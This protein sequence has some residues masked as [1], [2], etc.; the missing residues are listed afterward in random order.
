MAVAITKSKMSYF[1]ERENGEAPREKQEIN[2][3]AW[4]GIRTLIITG[5]EDGS[6]GAKYPKTCRDGT[7]VIGTDAQ[8]FSNAMQAEIPGLPEY[9]WRNQMT[10]SLSTLNILDMIEFCWKS[11]GKPN[12][13][14]YHDLALQHKLSLARQKEFSSLTQVRLPR[15][16]ARYEEL[17]AH[18]HLEFDFYDGREEFCEN[19]E[20]I[21]RRNGIAYELTEEGRIERLVPPVFS[22]ALVDAH[23][24][25]GDRE[26]DRLLR[27]AQEKFIDPD[28]DTRR[29]ALEALWD[30]WERLKTLDQDDK[31][32][33][34][35]AILDATA[36]SESSKFREALEEEAVAL[37]KIG[38]GLRIRHSETDQEKLA[39]S[40]HA[41]YLF[42]RLY[43]LI[44]LILRL[45]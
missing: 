8:A 22:E 41:D 28:P 42:Y 21:F 29:E 25:T 17:S 16:A 33:G 23:F 27:T 1:S 26:L 31:K 40:E 38:N 43:S 24:N 37:T 9:P 7:A 3:N 12:Q 20:E 32:S 4:R 18:H 14:E 2:E 11:I 10:D 30:A 39:Q 45:R 36:G 13:K 44:H 15:G 6:F 5:I 34:V 35:T 19:V